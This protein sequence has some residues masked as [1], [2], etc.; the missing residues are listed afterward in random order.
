MNEDCA[1][2]SERRACF[3]EFIQQ[4]G[5]AHDGLVA[6]GSHSKGQQEQ[7]DD[8]ERNAD[9][10]RGGEVDAH[11][12][13]SVDEQ[14]SAEHHGYGPTDAEDAVRS[15][16]DFE[17][18]QDHAEQ[19]Q[20]RAD[21]IDGQDHERGEAEQ[22]EDAS[23]DSGEDEA[24]RVELDIDAECADDQ[25][26]E[27]DVG[28]GDGADD[29]L[30]GG[31]PVIDDGG[32]GGV[33][34]FDAAI[35]AGDAA[36][37]EGGE[38]LLLAGRDDVDEV[39]IEGF[40][41]GEGFGFGDG[42]IGQVGV[43]AALED[44]AAQAGGGVVFDLLA[45]GF[46]HVAGEEDGGRG[47]GAG[48]GRHGGN[49][50]GLEEEEAGAG[51]AASTGGDVGDDGD[52]GRHDLRGDLAAGFEQSAGSVEAEEDGGG[53]LGGG[54]VDGVFDDFNGDGSDDAVDVYGDDLIRR[55]RGGGGCKEGEQRACGEVR[56]TTLL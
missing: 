43:A 28:I 32:S 49:V 8:R 48:A 53:V 5:V 41:F 12:G 52:A 23:G 38:E 55:S 27:A 19:Q 37:V 45:F 9:G 22:E 29:A 51:G 26:D 17:R 56:R 14:Q 46:A 50:G 40:F 24:G 11:F 16:F 34:G 31:E 6:A 4:S 13:R 42:F 25:Q 30:T 10:E 18:E 44:Y 21:P 3:T 15:E 1:G 39:V 35:E 36:A 33:E 7:S 20:G 47:S 54:L 2:R